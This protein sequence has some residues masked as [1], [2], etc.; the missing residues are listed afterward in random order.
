MNSTYRYTSEELE[1][2][3]QDNRRIWES[4]LYFVMAITA[5]LGLILGYLIRAWWG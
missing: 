5:V 1:R 2:I 4:R 3:V